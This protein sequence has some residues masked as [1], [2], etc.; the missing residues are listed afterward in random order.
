MKDKLFSFFKN[1]YKKLPVNYKMKNK[2]KGAFYRIFGFMFKNTTSYRVWS[3][4]NYKESRSDV[5]RADKSET[6]RYKC[7]GS[8]AV[9]LHLYYIDLLDE[10]IRYFNNIP[11]D[12]DILVSV[13]DRDKAG[14]VK[15]ELEKVNNVQNVYVETVN[16]RGRDVA[17][18]ICVFGKQILNYDYVYHVHSKK[19][20][21]TGGEQTDWRRYLLD[22]L[23]GSEDIVRSAF[24]FME[25]GEK[26][27]I[28]YPETFPGMPY[29]GHTWLQNTQSRDE[30]LNRIGVMAKDNHVY[31]DYPM[32]TMFLART[33]AIRQFFQA[34]IKADE[35]PKEGGQ[36]D[37]TIA[38][39]FERCLGTV[40]RYNGYNLLIY[41]E[42][43]ET[44]SYNYGLKNLNQ[45]MI[46]SY[47]TMRQEL[48]SYDVISFDI[49][50]TLVSRRISSGDGIL[51]LIELK[52]DKILNEKTDFKSKRK[53]AEI[54]YRNKYP[55]KDPDTDDIYNQLSALTGWSS[56]KI[57]KI[58]NIELETEYSIIE[59]KTELISLLKHVKHELDKK[60]YLISDMH[61]RKSDIEKILLKCGISDNDY[62]GLMV[63]SDMNLRKD[64]GT[65]WK[66]FV[67]LNEGKKC[68]HIGDNEVSDVQIPGDYKI[69]NYHVMAPKPLFQLSD[70]G[71]TAGAVNDTR[72][73]DS[74]E[75]GLILSSLF[76]E[77]FRYNTDKLKVKVSDG[78]EFGYNI[79]GPVVL[80]YILWLI[81]EAK[82]T[83]TKKILFFAREGYIFKKVFDIIKSYTKDECPDGEYLY[84]SRRALSLAAIEDESDI[85]S[86]LDIYYEGKLSNLVSKRFGISPDSVPDQ[87]IKLP[88]NKNKV[89]KFLEPYKSEILENAKKDRERYLSYLSHILADTD[90]TD[91]VI[92]SDIGYSGTIQYYLS[93]MA[94]RTFDG[95]YMAADNK[96]KPLAIEG[97]TITGYYADNDGEQEI[98]ES[99]VHKYHLLMESILIAP[100]GQFV[101]MDK[102]GC[103]VF[104][105]NKN[106]LYDNVISDIHRGIAEYA[107]AYAEIMGAAV[108]SEL[109]EK[110]L[111]ENLVNVVIKTDIAEK[112]ISDSLAVDDKYCSGQ[113]R[114]AAEYYKKRN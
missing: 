5:V 70:M 8:I 11:Y 99:F 89:M 60:V 69:P 49:F 68:I 79:M 17:P 101:K 6:C 102:E 113:V 46:K 61:L 1:I 67:S 38:H 30:L 107:E 51:S 73:S 26:T 3:S 13:V 40:C 43:E 96:K 82:K 84:V 72:A 92:V 31:I 4:I 58:K 44:Y 15:S 35:F 52:A 91:R 93:K 29:Q 14:D 41:D 21:F 95:R 111:A 83:G 37:G 59:P 10:F 39:A 80:N 108:I 94:H 65:M 103:P 50:D 78:K 110:E 33:D 90:N 19:S 18:F 7:K 71:R 88:D 22:G 28:I 12:F 64:N 112:S 36:T 75:F 109:P 87:D 25:M 47:D 77:P 20:L 57:N 32:G 97:N 9:Q 55:D 66:Y 105:E 23:M 63:S 81:N 34:D 56:E 27:G 98:S 54:I 74:A 86:P 62:D 16:N 104:E 114:N 42:N 100:D 45:Y 85:E 76:A 53:Q 48:S 2:L 106:P 24:Y